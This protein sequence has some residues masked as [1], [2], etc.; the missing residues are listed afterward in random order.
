[1]PWPICLSSKIFESKRKSGENRAG[2]NRQRNIL[3]C[4]GNPA[5]TGRNYDVESVWLSIEKETDTIPIL[6]YVGLAL[7]PQ[8]AGFLGV[9]KGS[10]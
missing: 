6:H 9:L 10:G 7:L 3:G 8:L 4:F 1:M 5:M 2:K